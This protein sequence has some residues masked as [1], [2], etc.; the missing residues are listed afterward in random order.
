MRD[1]VSLPVLSRPLLH[2]YMFVSPLIPALSLRL[3]A[4][5]TPPLSPFGQHMDRTCCPSHCHWPCPACTPAALHTVTAPAPPSH[6]VAELMS[7]L[8]AKLQQQLK[9]LAIGK[10]QEGEKC[11]G[12]MVIIAWHRC[13]YLNYLNYLN[14]LSH[15]KSDMY[16]PSGPSVTPTYSAFFTSFNLNAR[17]LDSLLLFQHLPP[18]LEEEPDPPRQDVHLF[19]KG[20]AEDS[21]MLP[22][23]LQ[24]LKSLPGATGVGLVCVEM[25][26]RQH[27]AEIQS[28]GRYLPH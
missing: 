21:V 10:G 23:A 8:V 22:N 14:Y 19:C 13:C 7:E 2:A 5:V 6:Y 25:P 28:S 9:R 1:A 18:F 11:N 17:A 3:R 20:V 12:I 15:S 16:I 26:T 27:T 24:V 4:P